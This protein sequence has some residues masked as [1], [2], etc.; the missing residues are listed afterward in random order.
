MEFVRGQ[1]VSLHETGELNHATI[2]HV[3]RVVV[4]V[5]WCWNQWVN[6]GIHS[7]CKG[8]GH[9]RKTTPIGY[10][11]IVCC[12]LQNPKPHAHAI[13]AQVLDFFYNSKLSHIVSLWLDYRFTFPCVG[14]HVMMNNLSPIPFTYGTHASMQG[15]RELLLISSGHWMRGLVHPGLVTSPRSHIETYETDDRS[16]TH[17]HT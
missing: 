10:C 5:A 17:S 1:M 15:H 6:K 12:T 7:G 3:G 2:R 9:P 4:V 8:S 13:W 11:H 16:W 14:S